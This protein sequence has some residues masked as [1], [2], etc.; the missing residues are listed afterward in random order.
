MAAKKSPGGKKCVRQTTKK[1][2]SRNSPPFPA[3]QC[4]GTVKEGNDGNMWESRGENIYRWYR[5]Y[6][7]A[8]KEQHKSPR[9][10]SPTSAKI[11]RKSPRMTH[12]KAVSPKKSKS[13]LHK[14]KVTKS[15]E[16]EKPKALTAYQLFMKKELPKFKKSHPSMDHREAFS[17]VAKMWKK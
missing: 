8:S 10:K 11:A 3:N 16:S 9:K 12:K 2:T 1:Y 15:K 6:N 14:T 17:A 7:A 5:Q 4:R 13:P